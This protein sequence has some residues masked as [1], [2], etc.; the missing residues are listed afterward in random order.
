MP[1]NT[2]DLRVR[3]AALARVIQAAHDHYVARGTRGNLRLPALTEAERVA[4]A[5]LLGSHV[6]VRPGETLTLSFARLDEA[7]RATALATGLPEAISAFTGETITTRAELKAAAEERWQQFRAEVQRLGQGPRS[8]AWVENLIGGESAAATVVRR[9]FQAAERG[10]PGQHRALLRSVEAVAA[11]LDQLPSDLGK[12]ARLPVFAREVTGDP[13]GFDDAQLAGRLF[14]RALTDLLGPACGVQAV[15]QS[16]VERGMLLTRAGLLPDGI[17]SAVACYG[18]LAA[19][20]QDG[21]V[22][23]LVAAAA[24]ESVPLVAALRQVGPWAQVSVQGAR[25]YAVENPAVFEELVDWLAESGRSVA[26]LCTSG[27]LSVAAWRVLDI[28][29]AQGLQIRYGG[30]FDLNGLRIAAGLIRRYGDQVGLWGMDPAAYRIAA[31]HPLAED[32][33]AQDLAQLQEFT[34][35]PLAPLAAAMAAEGKRAYQE[36]LLPLLKGALGGG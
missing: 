17:S 3:F 4:L 30:D 18:L 27:F 29:A 25:V 22:D 32:L 34:G 36:A 33:P 15:P 10:G 14:L 19:R 35:T 24:R 23:S 31:Q 28:A 20:R 5:G 9:E 2:N 6:K 16:A 12:T 1:G 26:L 11:A 21:S 13:H 7:L 8:R